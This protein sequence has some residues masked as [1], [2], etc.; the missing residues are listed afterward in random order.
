MT[1][2]TLYK[3]NLGQTAPWEAETGDTGMADRCRSII[4]DNLPRLY[5]AAP[6]SC[7]GSRATT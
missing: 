4:R 7:S 1:T 2:D 6:T 5:Q 3:I